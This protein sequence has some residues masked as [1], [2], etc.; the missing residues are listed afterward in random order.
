MVGTQ[1]PG[2]PLRPA[3]ET[4]GSSASA[5]AISSSAASGRDR[6]FGGAG[7]DRIDLR[8]GV[9]GNDD[10]DGGPGEDVCMKDAH[11]RRTSC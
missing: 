5:T 7:N 4:T 3:A 6:V 11:D 2:R 8:D 10:G 9:R 1:R